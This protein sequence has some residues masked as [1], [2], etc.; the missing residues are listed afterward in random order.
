MSKKTKSS[1]RSSYLRKSVKAIRTKVVPFAE[2]G[3]EKVGETV[4]SG[5]KKSAPVVKTGIIKAYTG[6][7]K[8]TPVIE[9]G[10]KRA[11]NTGESAIETLFKGTK[12]LLKRSKSKKGGKGRSNKR[13]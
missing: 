5:V 8:A 12:S 13:R 1:S 4:Y 9:T 11:F 3:L 7:K 10:A 6:I 2:R